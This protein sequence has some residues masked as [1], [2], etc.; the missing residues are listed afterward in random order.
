MMMYVIVIL[1]RVDDVSGEGGKA[2]RA[3]GVRNSDDL[4]VLAAFVPVHLAFVPV[5][6]VLRSTSKPHRPE[7]I[8]LSQKEAE[9]DFSSCVLP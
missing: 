5:V 6:G 2:R 3:R 1:V 9:N 7:D 8:A 4:E